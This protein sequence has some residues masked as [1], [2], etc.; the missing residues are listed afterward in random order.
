[1][2]DSRAL[3]SAA[4]DSRAAFFNIQV[5]FPI[6]AA[7]YARFVG[8]TMC[9]VIV[10]GCA[11]SSAPHGP[12]SAPA[13]LPV[14][15]A[16][17]N[18]SGALRRFELRINGVVA[19]DTVVGR[20]RD[21]TGMVMNDYVRLVPGRYDLILVDHLRQQEF[22]AR[23]TVEERNNCIRIAL[24]DSRTEFEAVNAVCTFA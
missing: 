12:Q 2:F 21:L 11:S 10:N 17:T 8:A 9:V 18:E 24:M 15:I 4:F 23:L 3:A 1:M 5:M 14:Q 16:V 22:R 7:K 13:A 6:L 20:P 19:K